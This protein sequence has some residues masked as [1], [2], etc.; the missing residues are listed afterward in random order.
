MFTLDEV[1]QKLPR[2]AAA[3]IYINLKGCWRWKGATGARGRPFVCWKGHSPYLHRALYAILYGKIPPNVILRHKC[4]DI[5]CINPAHLEQGSRKDNMHDAMRR[6][7]LNIK[8]PQE[9]VDALRKGS[10]LPKDCALKY[11]VTLKH[12][13]NILEGHK[14]TL[15]WD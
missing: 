6:Q 13:S 10:L 9:A 11:N 8:V 5:L 14:R 1:L 7:G 4:D 15:R 3:N 12:V 2:N